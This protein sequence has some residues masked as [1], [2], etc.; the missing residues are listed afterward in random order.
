[1]SAPRLYW[2]APDCTLF[3]GDVLETLRMLPD[4]Y[5]Q[6]CVTSPPYY[7]L[8]DYGVDGQ[9]GLEPTPDE[10]VANMVAV[11]RE[12]KRVL[13]NDGT[14]WLNIGDSY[15]GSG[16]GPSKSLQ[17]EASQNVRLLGSGDDKSDSN[18]GSRKYG[19]NDGKV[20]DGVKAKDLLGIPWLLAFA[21]RA[22]GWYLR[23]DI[24]WHKPNPMPESVTDR[25]TKS[26]EYLFLLAKSREYFY[27]TEASK[28][29][30]VTSGRTSGSTRRVSTH[31]PTHMGDSVPWTD[32]GQGRNR[33]DVW[34]INARPY[35]GAHF[36]TFPTALVEPCIK[37]G[38]PAGGLV[39]DPFGGSGTVGHVARSLGRESV[40]IELN[41]AYC[42]LAVARVGESAWPL[43]PL[44]LSLSER[45]VRG[46]SDEV[47]A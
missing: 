17:S 12:V 16:K 14:L 20:P 8:R 19:H 32:V 37:A 38:S 39:L 28:E 36:A 5:V 22:D 40:L 15:A 18:R 13:R 33:R 6:M 4:R 24:I 9:M 2:Q 45:P 34:S 10:Y 11:F 31:M 42:A 46:L 43:V 47:A 29:P 23:S 25:P 26:H 3:C 41:P 35:R 21:L 27:D 1:M 7:G 44:E 30:C